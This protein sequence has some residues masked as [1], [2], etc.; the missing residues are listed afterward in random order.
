MLVNLRGWRVHM[1]DTSHLWCEFLK[2]DSSKDTKL[3][4]VSVGSVS[5]CQRALNR[6]KRRDLVVND[7]PSLMAGWTC[8]SNI[9]ESLN[10]GLMN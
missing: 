8:F 1:T 3:Y 9:Q 6:Q 10:T 4:T 7:K 5:I 2:E